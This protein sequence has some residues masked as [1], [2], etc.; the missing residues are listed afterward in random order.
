MASGMLAGRDG[1]D[2]DWRP[3]YDAAAELRRR[4]VAEQDATTCDEIVARIGGMHLPQRWTHCAE[5][6]GI[7]TRWV[8]EI[9]E[10][11]EWLEPGPEPE[12]ER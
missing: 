4:F 5:L 8:V 1:P 9:A 6:V 10:Q 7:C 12:P 11:Q 2:D 3:S